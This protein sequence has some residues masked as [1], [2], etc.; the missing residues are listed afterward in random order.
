LPSLFAQG[1]AQGVEFVSEIA[2]G[3]KAQKRKRRFGLF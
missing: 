3:G 1:H 2:E